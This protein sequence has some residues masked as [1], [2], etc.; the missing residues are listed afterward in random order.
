MT[1]IEIAAKTDIGHHRE[2]N[3]DSFAICP[4]LTS[5]CWEETHSCVD[6]GEY[7]SLLVVADGMGGANAGEVASSLAM[8]TVKDQFTPTKIAS[9]IKD[10]KHIAQFLSE[11][12]ILAD[13]NIN[14]AMAQRPEI[15]GMGTTIVICWLL[16]DKAHVAW[17]GDSR[18][19]L[20]NK[21]SGLKALTKD[22][23][24]VQERVD[25]GEI[26]K[27][28]AFHH[29]DN[30]VIT[31]GLG[32]FDTGAVPDMATQP[33]SLNDTILLCSDGLCGYVDDQSIE[34]VMKGHYPNATRCCD[35]LM[36]TALQ[37]KADDNITIVIATLSDGKKGFRL[38]SI[39]ND[40]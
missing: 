35:A 14:E 29:P 23:S 10:E 16:N 34:K 17:C 38:F 15:Y 13:K 5:P 25:R 30:N 11:T 8:E 28:E 37:S 20:Y 6:F 40:K 3:E 39:F 24:L 1:K 2:Q 21:R 19:Y 9:V 4:D 7:G 12:I 22:H 32:D 31:R 27:E 33:L 26:T 18:C 36:D